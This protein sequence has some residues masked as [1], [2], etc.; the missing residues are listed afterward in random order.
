MK[1]LNLWSFGFSLWRNWDYWTARRH[2]LHFMSIVLA[3]LLSSGSC[4]FGKAVLSEP[5]V[6]K[7]ALLLICSWPWDSWNRTEAELCFPA[8]NSCLIPNK[9]SAKRTG[10]W[11][12]SF[13]CL[14]EKDISLEVKWT[15][16]SGGVVPF[17]SREALSNFL[18]FCFLTYKLEI[19]AAC[20]S[21]RD[22]V[23]KLIC[24]ECF[25]DYK[26]LWKC[27]L[28]YLGCFFPLGGYWKRIKSVSF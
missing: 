22:G 8:S 18:S 15:R 2:G 1:P 19:I 24:A 12:G 23:R 21:H 11:K 6:C 17:A 20:S 5:K 16:K 28:L 3:T 7:L 13:Q 4:L 26:A 10:F 27:K 25:E 9:V 14:A